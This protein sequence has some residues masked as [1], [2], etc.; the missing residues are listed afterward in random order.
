MTTVTT[1]RE[2]N[3]DMIQPEDWARPKAYSGTATPAFFIHDGGGTTY[4]YHCMRPISRFLYGIKNPH[5]FTGEV[6]EG[7]MAEMGRLYAAW[8]RKTA[9]QKDFPARRNPD[10]SVDILLG[11]WSLGGLLS[12]E[13]AREL[14]DDYGVRVAGIVMVDSIYPFMPSV[15]TT[16][17]APPDTSEKN[18][19]RNQILSQRAMNQAREMVHTWKL[20]V[21]EG[22]DAGRRP[23]TIMLRAKA[24]IPTEGEGIS[25]LDLYREDKN[26]GWD[27]YDKT[28][29]HKVLD[30]EGHH[31]DLFDE[32]RISETS[33][34]IRRALDMLG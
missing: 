22:W 12:L 27:Q 17:I 32:E 15:V 5:F 13:V 23:R 8:I 18:K 4:A 34:A 7:G 30:I 1:M 10:G 29:F 33:T 6:F 26:L 25:K 28:M 21:W 16:A 20:P 31:F 14:E 3:T 24:Y 9:A 11:G 2:V 19:T